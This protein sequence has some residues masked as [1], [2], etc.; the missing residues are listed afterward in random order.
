MRPF[1]PNRA[2]GRSAV[3]LF[4]LLG[5]AACAGALGGTTAVS[6]KG[7]SSLEIVQ[8]GAQ[9]A[10]AGRDLPTPIVLRVL[11]ASGQGVAGATVSLAVTAGGG[12]VT[13]ASDTTDSHGEFRAKWTLGAGVI[14]QSLI[15]AVPG[16]TPISIGATGLLPTQIVLLQGSNQTAKTATALTNGII[17]RVVSTGNVPMQGVTVGFQ[18]VAGGGGVTPT[19][20]VTNALGEASTKWTM[21]AAGAQM[22]SI[23]SGTLTPITV[24]ATATP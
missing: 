4:I 15:A 13:P 19:T 23:S 14:I 20:A 16:V 10:Q 12:T 11:D 17:V 18:V 2:L 3:A 9:T 5:L 8:G 1:S 7:P 21:G 22:M 6:A 24:T